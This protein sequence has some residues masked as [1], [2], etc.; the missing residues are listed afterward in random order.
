MLWVLIRIASTGRGDSNEYPQRMILYIK[1]GKSSS[2]RY[3]KNS[4]ISGVCAYKGYG[5]I[6]YVI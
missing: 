6:I 2:K 4:E 3:S 5:M 1:T